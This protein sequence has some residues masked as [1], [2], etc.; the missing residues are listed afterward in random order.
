MTNNDIKELTLSERQ[1]VAR[2]LRGLSAD[3]GRNAD[4]LKEN[5]AILAGLDFAF[6]KA[7]LARKL[8]SDTPPQS[9]AGSTAGRT[10]CPTNKRKSLLPAEAPM[11]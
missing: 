7:R 1:E 5:L 10:R 2:I 11:E 6:A 9:A 4:V 3:I 8:R